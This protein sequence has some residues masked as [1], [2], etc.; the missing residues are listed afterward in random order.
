MSPTSVANKKSILQQLEACGQDL[1][2]LTLL[3]YELL[4]P[5]KSGTKLI[6]LSGYKLSLIKSI[7]QEVIAVFSEKRSFF[8]FGGRKIEIYTDLHT[9]QFT[10]KNST[11][12]LTI[13]FRFNVEIRNLQIFIQG[14]NR[15]S[16]CHIDR[17]F[18]GD[19]LPVYVGVRQV[20]FIV[21]KERAIGPSARA[22]QS[23]TEMN[24]DEFELFCAMSLYYLFIS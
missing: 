20:G 16:I 6:K 5:H 21:N 1:I 3:E 13:D 17:N 11:A 7:F 15:L 22:F 19:Y 12:L 2:P 14:K 4:S 9:F 10:V 23:L 8:S 24:K 18:N